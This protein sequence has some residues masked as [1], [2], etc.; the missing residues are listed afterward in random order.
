METILFT[1][2]LKKNQ[3]SK[4]NLNKGCECP[5]QGELQPLKNEIE[6][7]YRR[8]KELLCSRIG[9]INMVKMAILPKPIYMFNAIPIKIPM[10]IITE[11]EKSTPKFIQK[12]KRP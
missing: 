2:A 9:R 1:I 5:L 7:D 11:I 6:E 4:S 8:W 3:I 10:I 12:H